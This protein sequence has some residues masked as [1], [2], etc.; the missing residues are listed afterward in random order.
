MLEIG[1]ESF[2]G[3]TDNVIVEAESGLLRQFGNKSDHFSDNL[4][5]FHTFFSGKL[6]HKIFQEQIAVLD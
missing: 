2:Q 1:K 4:K 6:F 5:G 3:L